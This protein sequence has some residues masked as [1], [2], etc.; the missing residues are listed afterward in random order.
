[1]LFIT[2]VINYMDRANLSIAMPALS[3]KFDLTTDQ[4]GLL[5]SAF[6]WTYAAMQLP[7]GWLVDRVRPRVLYASC[8]VLWSLATLFMGMSGGLVA[9][10]IL[11]LMVGG[12][13]A[14]AYPINDKVATAWFPERERGRVIAFYTS[15]Q[16]I[17][18]ALLTPV[19][20]WLQMVLTWHWVHT[21]V[22]G[23]DSGTISSHT[24][25]L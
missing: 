12:F 22:M 19:L 10:I 15:S 1:M 21:G 16:F 2:V 6:G 4:Q 3:P 7:G 14:P 9:L 18:L 25:P 11:R 17:G 23:E 8:L 13:E 5:L 24:I 20:P